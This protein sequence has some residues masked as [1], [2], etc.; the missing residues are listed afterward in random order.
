MKDEQ[1]I[2]H[3][4]LEGGLSLCVLVISTTYVMIVWKAA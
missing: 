1:R 3:D 2:C 4:C